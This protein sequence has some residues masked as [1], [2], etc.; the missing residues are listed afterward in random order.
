VSLSPGRR[1]FLADH[2]TNL[3]VAS[4]RAPPHRHRV[5]CDTRDPGGCAFFSSHS[6]TRPGVPCGPLDRADGRL[7]KGSTAAALLS[8]AERSACAAALPSRTAHRKSMLSL[9][10]PGGV[11]LE[12]LHHAGGALLSDCSAV[13]SAVRA[14][15]ERLPCLPRHTRRRGLRVSALRERRADGWKVVPSSLRRR[16]DFRSRWR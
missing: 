5:P 14:R 10:R 11:S 3:V 13:T 12:P 7:S 9:D 8:L 16:S 4:R 1:A 15:R 6:P 2:A